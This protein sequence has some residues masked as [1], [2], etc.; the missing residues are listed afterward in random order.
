MQNKRF[1]PFWGI[2][3][4]DLELC[5]NPTQKEFAILVLY[6]LES[7]FFL[8]SNSTYSILCYDYKFQWHINFMFEIACV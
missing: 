2:I 1:P 5:N 3:L 7:L 8:K 4:H 6:L